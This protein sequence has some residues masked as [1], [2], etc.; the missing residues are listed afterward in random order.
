ME[1]ENTIIFYYDFATDHHGQLIYRDLLDNYAND[2]MNPMTVIVFETEEDL[3]WLLKEIKTTNN[4]YSD[5]AGKTYGSCTPEYNKVHYE[6]CFGVH[7]GYTDHYDLHYHVRRE[8][9]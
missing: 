9:V 3:N 5:M 6:L 1:N 4:L 2:T 7:K 8:D